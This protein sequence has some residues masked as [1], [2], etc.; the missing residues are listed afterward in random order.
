M[1]LINNKK[2]H[3]SKNLSGKGKYVVKVVDKSTYK[4]STK[5][6]KIVKNKL[7]LQKDTLNK[8]KCDIK[9]IKCGAVVKM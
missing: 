1:A 7:K 3:E 9:N 8:V 4:A 2:T 5:N 6:P